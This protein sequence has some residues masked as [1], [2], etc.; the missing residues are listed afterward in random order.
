MADARAGGQPAL[1][2]WTNRAA[3]AATW[4]RGFP[5][6]RHAEL[7]ATWP[8]EAFRARMKRLSLRM[9]RACP[10][11]ASQHFTPLHRLMPRLGLELPP[12]LGDEALLYGR[13][14]AGEAPPAGLDG[15]SPARTRP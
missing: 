12:G 1:R 8:D 14:L 15:A 2:A 5:G 10:G 7:R 6:L 4:R 11:C 13:V 3:R 9:R